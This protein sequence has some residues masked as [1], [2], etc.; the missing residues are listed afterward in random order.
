MLNVVLLVKTVVPVAS[1]V[2]VDERTGTLIREGVPTTLNPWDYAAVDLCLRLKREYGAHVTAISMAPPFAKDVLD[3]L[4][5]MGIDEAVLVSDRAFAGSDTLATARVLA[6]TIRKIVQKFDLVVTGQ[7]AADSVTSHIPAQVA[8]LLDTPYLY[9]V[10][11]VTYCNLVDK[12]IRVERL[13]EDEGKIEEYEVKMP[14]VISV[15]KRQVH[16]PISPT[17]KLMSKIEKKVKIVTNKELSISPDKVGLAGSPTRVVKVENYTPP[18][19]AGTII[20][21]PLTEI[22]E[23]LLELIRK[24]REQAQ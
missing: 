21:K 10:T 5:G 20:D 22:V 19:R 12:I 8:A 18:Q 9:Y 3:D 23:W 4:I 14:I 2:K 13:L 7:E 24:Y 6:E 17:R 11:N 15:A 16:V 1:T